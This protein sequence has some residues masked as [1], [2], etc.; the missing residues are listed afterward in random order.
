[1]NSI[2]LK[3]VTYYIIRH[4]ATRQVMPLMKRG[5]GYTSWNPSS[6]KEEDKVFSATDLPRLIW[7]KEKA[8]RVI[9][10]WSFMPNGYVKHNWDGDSDID[11]K[12]DGRTKDDL[13]IVKIRIIKA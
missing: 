3:K 4:K 7:S 9:S 6:T 1:M 5:R 10:V 2:G 12:P 8:K 11:I 13:E